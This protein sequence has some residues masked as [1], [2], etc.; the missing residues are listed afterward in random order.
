MRQVAIR[1]G[2][3]IITMNALLGCG[4]SEL[5][6]MRSEAQSPFDKMMLHYRLRADVAYQM[7]EKLKSQKEL[8]Q[9]TAA[10]LESRSKA[11]SVELSIDKFDDRQ[12]HRFESYQ[13]FLSRDVNRMVTKAQT[14]KGLSTQQDFLAM[15]SQ[16][17]RVSQQLVQ[18]KREYLKQA[19]T[20]NQKMEQFPY[21]VYN[22]L[23]YH[24]TAMPDIGVVAKE[25]GL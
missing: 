9:E 21:W 18:M 10:V 1:I 3:V 16:Y 11:L 8:V 12:A 19:E 25:G 6:K 5:P 17:D 14:I 4:Y 23:K 15:V 20:F 13:N 2:A 22:R 7:A 24:Y